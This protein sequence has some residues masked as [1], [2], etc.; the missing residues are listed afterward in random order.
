MY[1]FCIISFQGWLPGQG[2]FDVM[3]SDATCLG[4]QWKMSPTPMLPSGLYWQSQ[5]CSKVGGYVCKK[6]K[7]SFG[8]FAFSN[9]TVTGTEGRLVSP[10]KYCTRTKKEQSRKHKCLKFKAYSTCCKYEY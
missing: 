3:P 5:K 10:G 6:P 8:N 9:F 4:L 1:E 2:Q 7:E